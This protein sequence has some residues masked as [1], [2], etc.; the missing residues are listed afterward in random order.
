[1]MSS[2]HS[3]FCDCFELFKCA[4]GVGQFKDVESAEYKSAVVAKGLPA[5][6][7][8]ACGAIAFTTK[9]A[10]R[11]KSIGQKAILV[12]DETSPEVSPNTNTYFFF[13][14]PL[15]PSSF[16]PSFL[17]FSFFF[18]LLLLLLFLLLQFI[19]MK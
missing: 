1:M 12:R 15:P 7:G 13:F 3:F 19:N 14:S 4:C 2:T 11:L 6:P 16:W 18:F 8:A 9:E 17:F 10:E 5:S